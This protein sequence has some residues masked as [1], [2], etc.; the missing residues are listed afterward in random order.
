MSL[1][2]ELVETIVE[3]ELNVLDTPVIYFDMDGVLADFSQGVAAQTGGDD[4]KTKKAFEEIVSKFPQFASLGD[5]ELKA[6]LAGAQVDPGMKALKKAW[7]RYREQKFAVAGTPGFFLS[8]P[9]LDGAGEMLARAAALT[10][11]KP[12]I[13]TAPIDGDTA[14]CEQEKRQWVEK[15]FPGMFSE[16][17]CT[18]DKHKYANSNS[19]LI[20]DRTK[21]TNKFDA[22][23]GTAILHKS[24][25][26]SMQKLENI[27]KSRGLPV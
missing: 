26:D 4:N 20:D 21:Y 27:L 2:K 6:R 9:V 14:R 13:L 11:R 18:Q 16:F 7:Q 8:L 1:L 19:I 5:D 3:A 24:P 22:N 15:N 12:N 23:G 25:E 10:G 17:I